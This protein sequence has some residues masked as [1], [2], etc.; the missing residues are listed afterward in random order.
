MLTSSL[1]LGEGRQVL[2]ESGLRGILGLVTTSSVCRTVIQVLLVMVL[3]PE[4]AA[5]DKATDDFNLGLGFYRGKRWEQAEETL[6]QFLK[7]FP[8]HSRTNLARLYHARTLS[9]LEKYGPAREEFQ[10]YIIAEPDSKDVADA[11]YRLGECSYFLKDYP[12]AI[13]Q[14]TEY[15]EK[16]SGHSHGDWARL[17]LGDSYVSQKEHDKAIAILNPLATSKTDP[18]ILAD[19]RFSLGKALEGLNRPQDAL[20]QYKL[21]VADS[22]S[23]PAPR[24]LNRIAAIQYAKGEY[25]EAAVSFEKMVTGYP[26]NSLVPSATLGVGMSL[27]RQREFEQALTWL[28]RIPKG[29]A[30][31][32]QGVLMTAMT[33]KELG[34]LEESRLVFAEALLAAGDTPLAADVLFQQAQMERVSGDKQV[35]AQ[36]F[37]DICDRWPTSTRVAESLFNAAELNLELAQREQAERIWNRLK[38]DYPDTA[39]RPREQILLGRMYLVRGEVEQSV[40]T[41]QK[42]I[43]ASD[44][45]K[46]RVTAVGQYYLVRAFYE[47]KQFDKVI[48]QTL[49]MSELFQ[50]E[51]LSEVRGALALAT[52]SCLE[53]KRYE[54]ALKFAD[55]FIP[56]AVDKTQKADV[57]AARAVTLSHL[58]RFP[59]AIEDLKLLVTDLPDLAQT[60]TA[61][62]KSGEA[63]LEQNVP[64]EAV[65]FFQLA[66]TC[67]KDPEVKEAGV[68]GLAWCQF[69]AAKYSE[70]EAAFVK[71]VADYPASEDAAQSLFMLARC[72]EEQ[73]DIE[74][75]AAAYSGVF[76][77]LAKDQ[78][79]FEAGSEMKPP[80][81]YAFDAGRQVARSLEKLKRFDDADKAWEKLVLAFPNAKDLDRLLDEWAWM[82]VS[83]ERFDRSDAVHQQLLERFP[84]SPYAGQ[85]RLSLAESLMSAGKLEESLKEMEAISTDVRYGATEKER[86]L[87]HVIEIQATR[88]QWQPLVAAADQFLASYVSS[89]LAAQVRLFSGNAMVELG[90]HEDAISLLTTLSQEIVSGKIPAQDWTD[91]VWVV[92][93]ESAL[94][95]MDY[96]RIDVLEAELKRQSP[97]SKFEFQIMDI[98]GRRWRQQAPPDF[99]KARE[100]F[101]KVTSSTEGAGT[102]TAARCQFLIAETL[103]L[104]MKLDEAVKE[105]FKVYVNYSYAELRAQA[106]FQ[107][108]VCESRLMKNEFAIRDFKELI[109]EFPTSSLVEKAREE[110]GKLEVQKP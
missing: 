75:T 17:L 3:F 68:T 62:L 72:I 30:S 13:L 88:R 53:Q 9:V 100:Y 70:A 63:A 31:S 76:E 46:S 1:F 41:L 33:L 106:L 27:Y 11:R 52:V 56:V 19:C 49:Q 18:G 77:K 15:L 14:L 110:L 5:A 55:E 20:A 89:P 6:S 81:Q 69:K 109:A 59:E 102:E 67:E 43:A 7:E 92:M 37:Q 78:P 48:D 105:Y 93:A 79:P 66:S 73:G 2:K 91:R 32:A 45:P 60:W 40:D 8:E 103:L 65:A 83:A 97:Q 12:A 94:A 99:L 101:G 29:T 64:D 74:R 10:Q 86:A 23:T 104:E 80:M 61:V 95:T 107:A 42:A 84:D 16:H 50:I 22:N 26:K 35:A 71:V 21:V 82:N 58:R 44:D 24:A 47:A 28:Q 85:A 54:E 25:K 108:A 57:M 87:F 96:E 36:I 90:R 4:M 38:T 98:Q 34:R 51:A 39:N